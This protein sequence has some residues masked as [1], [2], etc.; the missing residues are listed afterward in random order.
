VQVYI[1]SG[2]F[3]ILE[4]PVRIRRNR[5]LPAPLKSARAFI[6]TWDLR[7]LERSDFRTDTWKRLVRGLSDRL[8]ELRELN[9]IRHD[10][11]KTAAL[12]GQI[13][14]VKKILALADDVSASESVQSEQAS[15]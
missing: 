6:Y 3:L 10:E 14:E 5:P 2:K 13:S 11:V 4:A 7:V 12:R 8:Q 15:D 1:C 9:D